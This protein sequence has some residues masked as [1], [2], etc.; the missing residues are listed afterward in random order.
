MSEI[1]IE[2]TDGVVSVT[3]NRPER[4][5]ALTTGMFETLR[6]VI[7]EVAGNRADRVLLLRGAGGVF[8]SGG[9][10]S[11]DEHGE[12]NQ[13]SGS[14]AAHSLALI[15]DQV[16][17]AALALHQL[18]KPTI[19]AVVGLAAG[20]GAN[21]AFGCDL[22]YAEEGARFSE[23]FIRRALSIDCGGT[24]LLPRIVGLQRAK[25]L[26]FFGEW[27]GADEAERLGLVTRVFAKSDFEAA[28]RERA[29]KLAQ[30][31]PVA[32]ALTKR[33]LNDSFHATFSQALD[34]EAAA[35]A[36]CTGT[37]DFAE[38][39]RAFFEKRAPDFKGG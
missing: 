25:E 20:A 10:L 16:G 38:G 33:A 24:W 23:I 39:M 30:Q 37:D 34:Q 36:L 2:R 28:V 11:A 1:E 21:L 22:V 14:L 3:L 27:V 31:A 26:C 17:G 12:E 18:P 9:E 6:R 19:A 7:D 13:P 29:Q 4:R 8:C 15:R 35:Q 5:N 32:L